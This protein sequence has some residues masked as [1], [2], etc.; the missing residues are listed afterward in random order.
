MKPLGT[1]HTR[2][3]PNLEGHQDCGDCHPETKAG[4]AYERREAI[5]EEDLA[6]EGP[7]TEDKP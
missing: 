5:R 2:S 3:S 4:R 6:N 7:P 1:K